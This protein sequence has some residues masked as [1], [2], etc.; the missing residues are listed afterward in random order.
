[1]LL[2]RD[3]IGVLRTWQVHGFWAGVLEVLNL[4]VQAPQPDSGFVCLELPVATLLA[5][6]AI[7]L[8]RRNFCHEC[9][10][11]QGY[12]GPGTAAGTR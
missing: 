10:S 12:D 8:P 2:N 7:G 3:V 1:M 11:I 5:E 9:F 4:R 6:V